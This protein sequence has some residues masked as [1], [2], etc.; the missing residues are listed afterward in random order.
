MVRMTSLLRNIASIL[1]NFSVFF[2]VTFNKSSA[3]VCSRMKLEGV[4]YKIKWGETGTG[5]D[6]KHQQMH[7]RLE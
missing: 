4:Q 2:L 1:Y 3:D 7:L 5:Q 6:S